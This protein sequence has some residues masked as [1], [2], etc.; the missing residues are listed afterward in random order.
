MAREFGL[1]FRFLGRALVFN[2]AIGNQGI[3]K[4]EEGVKV[5]NLVDPFSSRKCQEC[6]P[7]F[8]A[9]IIVA[10]VLIT[11]WGYTTRALPPGLCHSATAKIL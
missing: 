7:F 11:R 10:G 9:G 6:L 4:A 3:I 1:S 2:F 8:G 5:C